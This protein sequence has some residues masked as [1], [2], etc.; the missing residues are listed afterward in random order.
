MGPGV[1]PIGVLRRALEPFPDARIVVAFSGGH[2]STALLAAALA[3]AHGRVRALHVDHG[4]H[5]DSSLWAGAAVALAARLGVTCRVERVQ[6]ETGERGRE[7]AARAA[8]REAYARELGSEELLLLAHHAED[9]AE[10]VLLRLAHGAGPEGLAAMRQRQRFGAGWLLRPWLELPRAALTRVLADAAL[11]WSED[12]S[13]FSLEFDRNYVRHRVLPPL[14][15]RWP[16]AASAIASSAALLGQFADAAARASAR[17]LARVQGLDPTT[18]DLIEL[19]RLERVQRGAVLRR[20]FIELG[21]APPGAAALRE[22]ER[23][24]LQAKAAA[25]PCVR[26]PG[27]ALR[28]YRSLVYASDGTT[29]PQPD[30]QPWNG[31]APVMLN[32]RSSLALEP[33]RDWPL[34][35]RRF[36]ASATLAVGAK[37]ETVSAQHA[38]QTLGVPPWL[39]R[40][41]P[42][43]Y[44][45]D[46]LVAIADLRLDHGFAER[47]RAG[48]TRLRYRSRHAMRDSRAD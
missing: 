31:N 23:S 16:H 32:D 46:R 3:C 10:T 41:L 12:P 38:L 13:N 14:T 47:L 17:E 30:A 37:G 1:D 11:G 18:L 25:A 4:L 5:P 22:I 21:F 42:F 45:H 48:G 33:A 24:L 19:L 6:V 28:R 27:G 2:D 44:E 39:R 35:I 36:R 8:R 29:P 26:W 9:Q 15:A 40:S 7:T 43:V 20:W 34:E